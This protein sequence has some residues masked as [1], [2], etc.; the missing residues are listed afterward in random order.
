MDFK[1]SQ[2]LN[3]AIVK[4]ASEVLK[5]NGVTFAG[6]S[7]HWDID[8]VGKVVSGLRVSGTVDVSKGAGGGGVG[9]GCDVLGGAP[10]GGGSGRSNHEDDG[11]SGG[12]IEFQYKGR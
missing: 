9:P 10:G 1:L 2:E 3:E 8:G 12:R 5:R 7:C 6:L 4:A 11:S